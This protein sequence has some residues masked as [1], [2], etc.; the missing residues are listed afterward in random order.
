MCIRDSHY[1][2]PPRWYH[3]TG[4]PSGPVVLVGGSIDFMDLSGARTDTYTYLDGGNDAFVA[5]PDLAYTYDASS[6]QTSLL[7]YSAG[8]W[9]AIE[10]SLPVQY[11]NAIW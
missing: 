4:F 1:E 10:T 2:T 11:P 7:R 3:L 9:N 6:T 8:S 5:G